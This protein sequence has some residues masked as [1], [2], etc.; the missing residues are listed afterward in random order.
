[1]KVLP[2][3][4]CVFWWQ[5][6]HTRR[7]SSNRVSLANWFYPFLYLWAGFAKVPPQFSGLGG[8]INIRSQHNTWSFLLVASARRS[9]FSSSFAPSSRRFYEPGMSYKILT[10]SRRVN[11]IPFELMSPSLLRR[12]TDSKRHKCVVLTL[13]LTEAKTGTSKPTSPTP[14]PKKKKRTNVGL[15]L[16]LT[17]HFVTLKLSMPQITSNSK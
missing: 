12:N 16:D 7:V 8:G 11:S 17:G 2:R 6:A 14:P 10:T 1:M 3:P 9:H 15:R 13:P 5:L 4:L